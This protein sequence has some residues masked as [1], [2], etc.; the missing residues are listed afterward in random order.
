MDSGFGIDERG[1]DSS[2]MEDRSSNT[3]DMENLMTIEKVIKFTWF[4]K[5]FWDFETIDD[6][7][8]NISNSFKKNIQQLDSLGTIFNTKHEEPC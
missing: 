8:Y 5:T 1:N 2:Q 6:S 4:E 7:T 3:K